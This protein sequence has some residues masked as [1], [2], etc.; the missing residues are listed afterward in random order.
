ML[1]EIDRK[2]LNLLQ[3]E[4]PLDPH[5]F[6]EIGRRVGLEEG[7]TLERVKKLKENGLIRRIGVVFDPGKLNYT[8]TLCGVRVDENKLMEVVEAVNRHSG[9]THNYEREG[10]LNLWFTVIAERE[11]DIEDFVQGLERAFSL[12]IYRFPKKRVF[13]I[14]TY[15]PM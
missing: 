2:I 10:D 3:E 15:F 6:A 13:K 12:K 1:D 4:F 14:K 8:S 9:V 5:P 11:G 7:E